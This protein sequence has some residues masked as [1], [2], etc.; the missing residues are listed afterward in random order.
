MVAAAVAV[1]ALAAARGDSC[2]RRFAAAAVA[3]AAVAA[4]VAAAR[5]EHLR[6]SD[7]ANPR[8]WLS[9]VPFRGV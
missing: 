7:A 5:A 8:V 9:I 2:L 6:S 4:V 1:W 3:V